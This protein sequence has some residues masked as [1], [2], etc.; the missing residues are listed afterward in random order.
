MIKNKDGFALLEGLLILIIFGLIGFI[1]LFVINTQK[2]AYSSY[3]NAAEG[4]KKFEYKIPIAKINNPKVFTNYTNE[5]SFKYPKDWVIREYKSTENDS[6]DVVS[7]GNVYLEPPD[8][9]LQFSKDTNDMFP[10]YANDRISAS[11]STTKSIDNDHVLNNFL[12]SYRS[13]SQGGGKVI[14]KKVNI[15]GSSATY[16]KIDVSIK[17]KYDSAY[18]DEVYLIKN[19]EY[20]VLMS[21]KE[22]INDPSSEN[23]Y[24]LSK[25]GPIFNAIA[26][27]FEFIK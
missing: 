10:E 21:F 26:H 19:N 2:F 9:P 13:Y 1:A 7:L 11:I 18:T 4:L 8:S 15:N 20:L 27:S 23:K 16:F 5:Y 24:D 12:K 25:S 6:A 14:E 3:D 17:K 22:K